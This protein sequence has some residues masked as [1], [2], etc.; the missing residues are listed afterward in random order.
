MLLTN[1]RL[2]ED[3]RSELT[4]DAAS[5]AKQASLRWHDLDP[6]VRREKIERAQKDADDAD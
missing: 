3:I 1:P 4:G 2:V 5:M 6:E